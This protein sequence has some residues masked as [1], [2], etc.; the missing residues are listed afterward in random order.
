MGM[1][2]IGL[3]GI[4]SGGSPISV[5]SRVHYRT[6]F[7]NAFWNG[8]SL[9]FGDCDGNQW[10][11]LVPLDIVAH[12]LMHGITQ[13]SSALIYDNQSGGLNEGF[14]D[15]AGSVMEFYINNAGD[16]PD[17]LVGE[18]LDGSFGV[19]RYMEDP[20]ADGRGSIDSICAY[21]DNIGVHFS[22]GVLNKAF[23][24][25]VRALEASSGKSERTCALVIGEIFL[26]SNIYMLTQSSKFTD[27][28]KAT[29]QS[30]FDND[31]EFSKNDLYDAIVIAWKAV[32]IDAVN[33]DISCSFGPQNHFSVL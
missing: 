6:D 21:N 32:D 18:E 4:G 33:E 14:S 1:N 27:A 13:F 8:N 5:Y 2:E 28:A 15:I 23:V 11:P 25:S 26:R 3:L 7:C 29:L 17:F 9:T 31:P 19:L 16:E 10:T 30:V 24:K 22:S 12:E 20:P